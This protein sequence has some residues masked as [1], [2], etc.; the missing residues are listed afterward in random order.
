[1]YKFNHAEQHLYLYG[2]IMQNYLR[3]EDFSAIVWA[4]KQRK[5]NDVFDASIQCCLLLIFPCI[6]T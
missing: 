6:C 4:E 3:L 2:L 1:M 5:H